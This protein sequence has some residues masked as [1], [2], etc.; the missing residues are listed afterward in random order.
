M[1]KLED[2]PCLYYIM[3]VR[4]I[5]YWIHILDMDDDRYPKRCYE[6]LKRLD[7]MERHNWASEI[8]LLL[9]KFGFES[10]W[11]QQCVPHRN[12]F[13]ANFR[14]KL[15][16][17]YIERWQTQLKNSSKLAIYSTFKL[18]FGLESYLGGCMSRQL[19]ITFARFRSSCLPLEIDNGRKS[20]LLVEERICKFCE[21][22]NL[23]IM[24]DEYHFLLC[25]PT[26][27]DIRYI[28]LKK[29]LGPNINIDYNLFMNLMSSG[30]FETIK[31]LA[32]CIHLSFKLRAELNTQNSAQKQN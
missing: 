9:C 4:C 15:K 7:N 14:E 16:E 8:R 3:H 29:Y 2:V 17:Y 6:L 28:F 23:S 10:V 26:Y 13:I 20:G 25:C 18:N 11:L 1:A 19:C 22:K 32:L 12:S 30:D 27:N 31:N 5:N 24:E 21:A